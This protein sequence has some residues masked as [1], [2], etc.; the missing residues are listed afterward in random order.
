MCVCDWVRHVHVRGLHSN[1]T[2]VDR[3]GISHSI[4]HWQTGNLREALI[5]LYMSICLPL[6]H[7]WHTVCCSVHLHLAW[8]WG[9]IEKQERIFWRSPALLQ[10]HF[11]DLSALPF[12]PVSLYSDRKILKHHCCQTSYESKCINRAECCNTVNGR[13]SYKKRAWEI[14]MKPCSASQK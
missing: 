9:N 13:S 6:P 2:A 11:L 10:P 14:W 12:S 5:C 4:I 3:E 8:G 1:S 7:T